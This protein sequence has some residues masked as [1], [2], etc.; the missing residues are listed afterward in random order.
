MRQQI[1]GIPWSLSGAQYPSQTYQRISHQTQYNQTTPPSDCIC[2]WGPL[3]LRAPGT[4]SLDYCVGLGMGARK[5]SAFNYN[6]KSFWSHLGWAWCHYLSPVI[7]PA[8][9][10]IGGYHNG[11]WYFS[12]IYIPDSGSCQL[13]SVNGHDLRYVQALKSY[14]QGSFSVTSFLEVTIISLQKSSE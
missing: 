12:C 4:K 6:T 7:R 1:L 9:A 14:L 3:I 13:V 8:Q 10:A 2:S 11:F 5:P